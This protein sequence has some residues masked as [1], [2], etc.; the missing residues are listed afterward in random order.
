MST[1]KKKALICYYATGRGICHDAEILRDGLLGMGWEVSVR[2]L[3]QRSFP[4]WFYR[5]RSE[6]WDR[7]LPDGIKT[8]FLKLFLNTAGILMPPSHD[9]V[10]ILE[11]V[12]FPSL[13]RGR[14]RVLIP[15]QEWYLERERYV[16]PMMDAVFTKTAHGTEIFRQYH[17]CVLQ[18]GFD[19]RDRYR[20]DLP[21]DYSAYIHI[22]GRSR[23]KGTQTLVDVWAR[24]PEWPLL[25]VLYQRP[26]KLPAHCNNILVYGAPVSDE[27]LAELQ[28]SHGVHICPSE[29]EGYGHYIMEAMSCEA[30]VVT[31]DAPPMNEFIRPDRGILV[32]I[33]GQRR[34]RLGYAYQVD[35]DQLERILDQVIHMPRETK[36]NLG[37][38]AR[39]HFLQNRGDFSLR[40][41]RAIDSRGLGPARPVKTIALLPDDLRAG[42]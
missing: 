26:L 20:P 33:C 36:R 2:E 25:K 3:R 6:I 9:L 35:P 21:K 10:L 15:N 8:R 1:Q 37:R 28:N 12:H 38:M 11:R 34:K 31:T 19:S 18:T 24:H 32:P 7:L 13:T 40:L 39:W 5:L 41:E 42:K 22:A 23:Q 14:Q 27:L 4:G 17:P 29:A 30:L 16:I